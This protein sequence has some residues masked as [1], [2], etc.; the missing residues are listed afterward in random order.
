MSTPN[1]HYGYTEISNIMSRCKTVLFIGAG[2]IMMSSLALLTK[3]AGFSV[4]ASDRT[5]TAITEKLEENGIEMHY[6]HDE[7]N[8]ERADA[9]VYTV[10]ILQDNPE[11]KRAKERNIPCI[12]RADYLGYLMIGYK[13]RIGI[14]G[15]HGK[16]TCTSMTS[17]IFMNADADPTVVSGAE[18]CEM[19]GAYL[20]GGKEH[21]IFEAC[22][23]M[24]SFLD[25]NP[26]I[27][28][29]LNIELEH[30]DYFKSLEQIKESF[31]SY[32][33]L[34]EK[35][36]VTVANIT[37]GNVVDALKDYQGRLVTVAVDKEA[38]YTA[39]N[40]RLNGGYPEFD[41]LKMGVRW[42]RI[43]LSVC[44]K[45][46][47]NNALAS[48]AV[49]D[50]C[51]ISKEMIEEGLALF[52]GAHRR[53]E[54][55][56]K[57]N[58]AKV[59]D[60]YGHH[61]TEVR[62]TL[63]GAREICRSHKLICAFQPHTYSRTYAL[64]DDLAAAFELADKVVFVDIYAAREK[65]EGK[66]S[67]KM[68]ADMVGEKAVYAPDLVS[69]ARKVTELCE[70]CDVAVIMGAGNICDLFKYLDFDKD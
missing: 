34:A 43:K 1:T 37:D 11:Y 13:N 65:D 59:Y 18:M 32:A 63:E 69:C 62:A 9:V 17:L 70:P 57:I 36:G 60:D 22:E 21:F 29:I 4:I 50:L 28:V 24:D 46:N 47:I 51:G 66:I 40:I 5:K 26:S 3:K 15:M 8:A 19:G 64:K 44:G 53:M 31:R 58:S 56:G 67:S 2:G 10:A 68:L 42:A 35:D 25:F 27:A 16:S 14:A 39:T 6:E 20:C 49:A 23:Y 12:S 33:G 41:I 7:R 48:A 38:D 52:K 61:P 54:Y 30:V 55:K 45:H